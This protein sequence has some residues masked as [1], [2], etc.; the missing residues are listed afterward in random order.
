MGS[1]DLRGKVYS[2]LF[3]SQGY[4]VYLAIQPYIIDCVE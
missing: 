4:I 2:V 1:F 3:V